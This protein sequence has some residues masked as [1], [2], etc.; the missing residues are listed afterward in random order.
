MSLVVMAGG[1]RNELAPLERA[2][3]GHS[4]FQNAVF[5]IS[6]MMDNLQNNRH[7]YW[8]SVFNIVTCISDY[9]RGLDS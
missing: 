1:I 5:E 2:C 9:R 8:K 7:V 4:N 6:K 3:F